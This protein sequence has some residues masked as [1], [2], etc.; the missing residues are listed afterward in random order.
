MDPPSAGTVPCPECGKDVSVSL[1]RSATRRT[2]TAEPDDELDGVT[3]D[4]EQRTR[5]LSFTCPVD[6]D[7]YVY[8]EW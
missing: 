8:F 4:A 3:D 7:V 6:H 5:R 2:V 1:P